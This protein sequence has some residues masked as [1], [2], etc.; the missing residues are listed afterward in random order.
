MEVVPRKNKTGAAI[1]QYIFYL[2][3]KERLRNASGHE[4]INKKINELFEKA[5]SIFPTC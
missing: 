4:I 2:W 1:K 3:S 5:G